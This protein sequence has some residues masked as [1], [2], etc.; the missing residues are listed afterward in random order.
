MPLKYHLSHLPS[1]K[2]GKTLA[3]LPVQMGFEVILDTL[4]SKVA[5]GWSDVTG[6]TRR[7]VITDELKIVVEKNRLRN[8]F[9]ILINSVHQRYGNCALDISS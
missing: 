8:L 2:E 3:V 6:D 5:E 7:V 1:F 9:V 4:L